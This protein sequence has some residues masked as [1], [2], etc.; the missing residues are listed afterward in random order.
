[1]QPKSFE[2]NSSQNQY[3]LELLVGAIQNGHFWYLKYLIIIKSIPKMALQ[4][5]IGPSPFGFLCMISL[6]WKNELTNTSFYSNDLK[7]DAKIPKKTKENKNVKNAM[8]R[9]CCIIE[10]VSENMCVSV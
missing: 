9:G 3:H 6:C 2:P 4:F 5:S 1:M 8:K 7:S 10:I